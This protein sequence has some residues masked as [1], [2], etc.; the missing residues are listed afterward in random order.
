[1]KG[2]VH[3]WKLAIPATLAGLTAIQ[4]TLNEAELARAARFIHERDQARFIYCRATLR[5]V[6]SRYLEVPAAEIV[7]DTGPNGKPLLANAPR[8]HFNLSHS[9]DLAAIAISHDAPVGIDVEFIDPDF[10]YKDVARDVLTPSEICPTPARFYQLW[11][12]KE[13]LLKASGTG[14]SIDPRK[15]EFDENDNLISAPPQLRAAHVRTLFFNAVYA[16]ALAVMGEMGEILTYE[17]A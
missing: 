2:E 16:G 5:T 6:L 8:W 12:L 17:N 10:P 1:M 11:T 3:V 4:E 14:F 9:R 13:A 15:I 7:F